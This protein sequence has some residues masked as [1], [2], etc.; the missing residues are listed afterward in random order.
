MAGAS[1]LCATDLTEHS[2][3]VLE[4]G[5]AAA[6]AFGARLDLVHVIDDA[7]SWWPES[8]ELEEVTDQARE[9][10]T[11][12]EATLE[13]QLQDEQ[14][15]C[16]AAGIEC[17]ALVVRGRPWR[18]IPEIAQERSSFLIVIGAYGSGGEHE[19]KRGGVTE[20]VLGSTAD[21][22]VRAADRPVFVSTG[23]SPIPDGLAGAKWLVGTDFSESSLAALSWARRAVARVGGELFVANVVIPAGGEDKPDEE[24][25]WRQVLRDQSKL[26]AGKKLVDYLAEHA[27]EAEHIQVVSPDY[28]SH[29]L[30]DAA[31]MVKADVMVIGNRHQSVLGRL[32]LGSTASRCLQVAP[33]PVLMVPEGAR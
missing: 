19:F 33:M 26:E 6:K 20:R 18:L 16:T 11:R 21:R 3:R 7:D 14:K 17:E 28:P 24:R 12:Y 2:D 4:L 1:I 27:P 23:E 31:E 10:T 25:T 15:R 29:A 30:C 22:V 8:P 32:L 5:V 9:H 13:A